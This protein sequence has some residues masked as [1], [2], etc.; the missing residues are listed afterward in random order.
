MTAAP[1]PFETQQGRPKRHRFRDFWQR[2]TEGIELDVL[3]RQFLSEAK[4][5]Y[6]VYAKDVDWDEVGNA[7]GPR[8]IFRTILALF[9]AMLMKLSPARRV[10]LLI[11]IALLLIQPDVR[12]GEKQEFSLHMGGF[13]VAIL[14]ILLAVELADRVTMKRDLEIAREIQQWL[15]P[16]SAPKVDGIDIAFSTRPQNTVAGDYYDAFLRPVPPQSAAVGPL[17]VAVA[18]VAGKSVPAAL[19]MATF[20]ASLRALAITPVPLGEIVDGLDRYCRAHSLDGRRFTTAFLAEIDLRTREMHYVNAGHNDPILLHVSGA[21]E[22][23]SA[24][25][26][27]FGLPS[28]TDE[29]IAYASARVQLQPGDLLVIFTDGLVEAINDSEEEY[30]E[31]RLLASIE[32]AANESSEAML[33][34]IMAGVNAFAG[35]AR[36]HDDITCLVLRVTP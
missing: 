23:L 29:P 4:S 26:P 21:I 6:R 31:S 8:R 22:R 28:F 20:Q 9:Q 32:S 33:K 27:P 17:L 24:G 36:Q 7:R 2:V 34:R 25:G 35:A 11:A 10:L 1:R 5:S 14:F 15:V 19:L 3:G 13:G 18:D 16:E 30:R 12:W